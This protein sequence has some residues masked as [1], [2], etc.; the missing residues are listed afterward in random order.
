MTDNFENT[1]Y[2]LD[3]PA[4]RAFSIVPSSAEL[5]L[6]TR[7][8]YVGT[9]G[10]VTGVT[11]GGDSVTFIGVLAGTVLP[12]RFTIITAASTA[13]NLVGLA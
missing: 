7:G 13:S 12:V 2:S 8:V 11:A 10:S 6:V 1:S 9:A 5:P 3:S 4:S